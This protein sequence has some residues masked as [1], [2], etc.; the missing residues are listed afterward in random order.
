MESFVTGQMR[1]DLDFRPGT[2]A[3]LFGAEGTPEIPTVPSDFNQLR[4]QL[5]QLQLPELADAAKQAFSSLGRVS[6]HLDATLDPLVQSVRG[7]ADAATQTLQTAEGAVRQ[8]QAEASIALRDLHALLVDADRQ[9][10][11]RGGELSH[12]LTGADRAIRKA[13]T[14]LDSLNGL[15]EPRSQVRG[16]LEAAIHDLAVTASSLRNFAATV[17]RNPNTLLMGRGSR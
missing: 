11:A 15:V 6:D 3:R 4:N 7:A 12:A 13:Q 17:E 10:D 1:V 8:V 16:D 2:P 14:L 5:A 9:L